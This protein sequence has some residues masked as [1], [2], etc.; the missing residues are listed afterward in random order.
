M[1]K[2]EKDEA[3]FLHVQSA[4]WHVAS[5]PYSVNICWGNKID[6]TDW[7]DK[8]Q[9]SRTSAVPT[10]RSLGILDREAELQVGTV[11]GVKGRGFT[12]A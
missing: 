12:W 1:D 8:A 7:H 5:A 9:V 6:V 3:R 2:K 4:G 10:S 11:S